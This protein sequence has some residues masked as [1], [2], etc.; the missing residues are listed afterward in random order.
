[1]KILSVIGALVAV[2]SLSGATIT[3][4][5]SASGVMLGSTVAVAV[6]VNGLDAGASPA[7]GVYDITLNYDPAVLTYASISWGT[8]LDVLGLGSL[9]NLS[10]DQNTVRLFELSLDLAE[11]LNSL[12]PDAFRLAT[13]SFQATGPGTSSLNLMST[14][15]G[16]AFGDP[17]QLSVVNGS[18]GVQATDQVPEPQYSLLGGLSLVILVATQ[19]GIARRQHG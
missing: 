1:M 16:D 6:D 10:F 3:V 8:G 15:L 7:L 18:V 5:P 9:R 19:R 17:L 13:I 4:L 2:S 14:T 12:Q 11:D